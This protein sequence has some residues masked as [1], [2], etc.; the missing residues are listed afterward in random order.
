MPFR[1]I[2]RDIKL[3]AIR[4]HEQEILPL[5]TILACL[6]ISKSTFY[7][8]LDL[9]ERTGDVI[10]HTYGL[11]GRP[12]LLH[13]EDID[14][15]KRLI[16]HRPD[17]FLDELLHLLA[18]NRF[19]S[20]HYVTIHRELE[21]AGMS[22]KKLKKIARERNENLRADFVRHMAQYL[23]EQLGFLDE[24]SKDER[25]SFRTRGRSLKGTRAQKKGVFIRGRRVSAEGL[26]TID[27]M[28]SN[29]VI[30]GSMNRVR[31]LKYLEL[32]V[33]CFS[34]SSQSKLI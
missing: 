29:T 34:L 22:T 7:R 31:F 6:Q 23:P 26:L 28:I 30:E 33:V 21:R 25:T 1:K 9:W 12:R 18:T 11:R 16:K 4:M 14:Y 2:S 19:I 27:G 3:A 17:W 32:P 8:I 15:L 5:H 10:K 20:A 24:V 13:F